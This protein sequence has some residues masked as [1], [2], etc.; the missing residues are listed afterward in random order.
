MA[1]FPG[2]SGANLIWLETKANKAAPKTISRSG[3]EENLAR[4]GSSFFI[5]INYRR[6]NFHL[7]KCRV[8]FYE[9]GSGCQVFRA[10]PATAAAWSACEWS[11]N[12]MQSLSCLCMRA[13]IE[14]LY[15][16]PVG[17]RAGERATRNTQKGE[18]WSGWLRILRF[19]GRK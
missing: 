9:F 5:H 11:S 2:T 18:K 16:H 4:R 7:K 13:R 12:K 1:V 3:S 6:I 8:A 19:A 15:T 14:N 17:G 10:D